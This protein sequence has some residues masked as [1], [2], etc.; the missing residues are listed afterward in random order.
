MGVIPQELERVGAHRHGREAQG[1]HVL[2]ARA[3]IASAMA[4]LRQSSAATR[5][6]A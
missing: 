1:L 3:A 4:A 2:A 5:P 6:L